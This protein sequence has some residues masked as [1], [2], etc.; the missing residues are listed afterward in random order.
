MS[1]GV[2]N[3]N[4]RAEIGSRILTVEQREGSWTDWSTEPETKRE[5][6]YWTV[7]DKDTQQQIGSFGMAVEMATKEA[8]MKEGERFGSK[9]DWPMVDPDEL[10]EHKRTDADG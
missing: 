9:W 1:D 6:P 2:L 10:A 7:I 5:G 4:W 8:A 3:R